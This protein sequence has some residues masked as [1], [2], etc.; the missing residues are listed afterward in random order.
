VGC[1]RAEF[2]PACFWFLG[3]AD[4]ESNITTRRKARP[5]DEGKDRGGG[6]AG[7]CGSLPG[8]YLTLGRECLRLL[9]SSTPVWVVRSASSF[10]ASHTDSCL[11]D[12]T[13]HSLQL[14]AF[15]ECLLCAFCL[16]GH[17]T[18]PIRPRTSKSTSGPHA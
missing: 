17:H 18:E 16:L 1:E 2:C 7:R 12:R 8:N 10:L 15:S 13:F 4:A 6:Q 11:L 9:S 5:G 14:P 3:Q